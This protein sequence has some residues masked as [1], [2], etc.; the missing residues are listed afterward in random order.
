MIVER[1]NPTTASADGLYVYC[2]ARGDGPCLLGAIGLEGKTVYGVAAGGIR[3]VVHD[4]R[5][6]PYQS[7]DPHVL[8]GWLASHQDVV[9]AATQAFGTVLPMA[10]DMIVRGDAQTGTLAAMKGWLEQ[11]RERFTRLLDRLAS[12]AEYGVQV[13]WDRAV[14]AAALVEG[15]APLRALRDEAMSKP[16]GLA[17]LLQQKLAKATREALEMQAQAFAQDF[18]ARIRGCVD[19]V[20]VEPLKKGDGPG[21]M[22]LNLSCLMPEGEREL[23]DVLDAIQALEGVTVRFTGPWPPYSFV[24]A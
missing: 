20:R 3:A 8:K 1:E 4:C 21:Q 24:G 9:S 12:K 7:Q 2:V 15:R 18:Y 14:I 10:F 23:G 16:R 13:L 5:P 22:L 6:E 11:N 19:D 17:H